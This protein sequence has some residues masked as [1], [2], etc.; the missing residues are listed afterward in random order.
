MKTTLLITALVSLPPLAIAQTVPAPESIRAEGVPPIPASLSAALNRYQ[1]IRA[2]SFQDWD[3]TRDRAMY[4]TTRFA[5]TPQ[6]HHVAAPGATRRQLTFLPER[7][8][9]VSA[10]PR[11]DQFLYA[12]DEGG[13]E[14]YQ[15]F[16]Q[17][18]TG[19]GPRRITDGKSRNISPSWSPSGEL[20]A[21]SSNA[22]NGRDMDLYLAAPADPHFQRLL[23]E[24]SG[25]WTVAD[26]SPDETRV[27][28]EEYISSNESYIYLIDVSTSQTTSITPRRADAKAEPVF[29]GVAKWSKDGKAIYYI[30]DRASEFRRLTRHD[31]VTGV[32]TVLSG[33]IPWD[34]EDYD[35][36]DDGTL[37]AAVANEDGRDVLHVIQAATGSERA[38]RDLAAGQLS[39]LK[40]RKGSHELG[41]TRSSAQESADAYSFDLD[42]ALEPASAPGMGLSPQRWT[43]S[44]TGGLDTLA[45]S[46]PR[47]IHYRS[48]DGRQI[49]AF[50]YRPPAARFPSPRPVLIEIHG[51]PEAQFRPGFLGR[52]NY[53][54]NELGLVLIM[55]NVRGSSGYGKTYV[56]LD[57]G[58]LREGAVKDIGTLLDWIAQQREL[59]NG[60]IAVSGRSYGWFI[61]LAV[62]TT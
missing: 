13:A 34:I 30:T 10:R 46:E 49:P 14:N 1:N 29:A 8:L 20:L 56:K 16:L 35:L 2:A 39:G 40:F 43:E 15:L 11:H 9:N 25:Q 62:Q 38:E 12:M 37:I 3:D 7:V 48:F 59:D 47:L 36:S 4:I 50:I 41:F 5:E 55:P 54:C 21:W 51:G 28:A 27:V 24:V 61:A 23:K 6:V 17:D 19:G 22:R 32:D 52:L 45:F 53:L 42:A 57:N 26:W 18:R 58:M 60:R 33:S 44:E 31:L